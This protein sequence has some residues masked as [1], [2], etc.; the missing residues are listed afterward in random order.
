MSAQP[1]MPLWPILLFLPIVAIGLTLLMRGLKGVAIDDHPICRACGFDLFGRPEEAS[2]CSECGA[3]LAGP[4]AIQIG[5]RRRRPV[6]ASVGGLLVLPALLLIGLIA[7]A[8]LGSV[9]LLQYEPAWYLL[10]RCKTN[11]AND[12][13]TVLD[14]LMSRMTAGS[15][16]KAD[17]D[18]L[19]DIALAVQAD[20][21][22]PWDTKWGDAIDAA[23]KTGNLPAE[24]YQQYAANAAQFSLA[25]RPET[26]RGDDL[27]VRI[28]EQAA[29]CGE[30]TSFNAWFDVTAVSS[31]L[32]SV[33]NN[34]LL[35][36]R[37]G[38][39]ITP[40]GSSSTLHHVK[41]DPKLLAAAADGERVLRLRLKVDVYD[42][43]TN[44]LSPAVA[45]KT[46]DLQ[47]PWKLV[48]A[49][50]P[51]VKAINDPSVRD[52]VANGIDVSRI[53]VRDN[54]GDYAS[55]RISLNTPPVPLAYKVIIRAADGKEW[56]VCGIYVQKG[57]KTSW[58]TGASVKG[59][60]GNK[61][62]VIFRPDERVALE[63]TE[64]REYYNEEIVLKGV[65]VL[66]PKPATKP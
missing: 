27:M 26:R 31:E 14:E 37:D 21:T 54:G 29:R 12:R 38:S 41:L 10:H 47:A 4:Q 53:E 1:M 8:S 30:R 16:A 44:G 49:D 3:A 62:D 50:A 25:V 36:G 66:R 35:R 40:H 61:V 11:D 46:V 2:V 22:K 13:Q 64:M 51:T 18:E 58:S 56:P 59:L 20:L 24:K 17:I 48:P 28:T 23:R 32:I 15:L 6:M 57:G 43:W 60:V 9:N 34:G 33:D 39:T 19:S 7:W 42:H 55:A 45:S 65:A 52:A 5:R 63:T